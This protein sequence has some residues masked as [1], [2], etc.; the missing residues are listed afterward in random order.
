[1]IIGSREDDDTGS[2][3]L[4]CSLIHMNGSSGTAGIDHN[5]LDAGNLIE[6]VS[7]IIKIDIIRLA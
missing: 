5:D 1:M 3:E 4:S 2:Y 6:S 7:Q